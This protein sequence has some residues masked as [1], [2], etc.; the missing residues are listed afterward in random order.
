MKAW[1]FDDFKS[2]EHLRLH[3]E[4]DAKPQRGEVQLRIHAVSLNYRDIAM[5]MGKYPRAYKAG[6]IPTSD[7]AGEVIAVG[8]GVTSFR[9]GDRVIG[10]FHPRWFGGPMHPSMGQEAYGDR[11]TAGS[12]RRKSSARR[13]SSN[14]VTRCHTKRPR[15]CPAPV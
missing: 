7:G 1:R 10:T 14:S 13:P 6:L 15:P 9:P 4:P 5:L 2:L 12:R 8:E 11:T 3:D